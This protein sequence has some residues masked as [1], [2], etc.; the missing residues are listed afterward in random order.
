MKT[1]LKKL[2]NQINSN[3][4]VCI[5]KSKNE[6]DNIIRFDNDYTSDV[7]EAKI[8]DASEIN[9][10]EEWQEFQNLKEVVMREV[11]LLNDDDEKITVIMVINNLLSLVPKENQYRLE[12]ARVKRNSEDAYCDYVEDVA[13]F[14]NLEDAKSFADFLIDLGEFDTANGIAAVAD[15]DEYIYELQIHDDVNNDEYLYQNAL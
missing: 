6:L 8:F 15:D 9:N 5:D 2:A 7:F 10:P 4:Y 1:T 14:D 3:Q 12:L 11:E 13:T